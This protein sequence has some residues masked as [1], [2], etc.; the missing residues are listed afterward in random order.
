MRLFVSSSLP[1]M[2]IGQILTFYHGRLTG[3][4]PRMLAAFASDP[5]STRSSTNGS[6]SSTDWTQFSCHPICL[7]SDNPLLTEYFVVNI[8]TSGDSIGRDS[9]L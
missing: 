2:L 9:A 6:E 8:V 4:N 7:M 5:I 1:P 3:K